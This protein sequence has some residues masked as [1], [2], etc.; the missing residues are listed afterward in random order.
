MFGEINIRG[1]LPVTIPSL[2]NYHDGIQV[3]ATRPLH[4]SG[5]T[6]EPR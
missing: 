2:A 3:Q 5:S 4:I 6:A 1:R